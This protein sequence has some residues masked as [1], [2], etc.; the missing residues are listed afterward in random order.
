MD[1]RM[2][3]HK[4]RI[5]PTL[6]RMP[7]AKVVEEMCKTHAT[8]DPGG[9]HSERSHAY[10]SSSRLYPKSV[11]AMINRWISPVPS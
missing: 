3:R 6:K 2:S 7:R 8:T 5:V 4:S 11:R 9:P 10:L 1:S